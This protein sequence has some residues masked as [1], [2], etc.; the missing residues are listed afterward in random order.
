MSVYGVAFPGRS[1]PYPKIP[2]Q[3]NGSEVVQAVTSIPVALH[4][5]HGPGGIGFGIEGSTVF[6]HL[7]QGLVSYYSFQK[8]IFHQRFNDPNP[9]TGV[10]A[11]PHMQVSPMPGW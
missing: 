6:K 9:K 1:H 5:L 2:A 11:C 10:L 4:H 7:L 8:R 3:R